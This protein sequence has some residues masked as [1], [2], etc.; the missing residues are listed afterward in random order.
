MSKL[1][2]AVHEPAA[3]I[4]LTD[5]ILESIAASPAPGL[6]KAQHLMERLR[7]PIAPHISLHLATSPHISPP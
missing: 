1:Q 3:F 7:C 6:E 5:A 4:S 2:D